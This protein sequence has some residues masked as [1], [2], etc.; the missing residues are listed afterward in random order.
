MKV[1][2]HIISSGIISYIVYLLSANS[3]SNAVASF[4]A[5]ILIDADH[6]LDYFL[7]YG[8]SCNLR[9]IYEVLDKMKINRIYLI[10]HSYELLIIFWASIFLIPLNSLYLAMAIGFTQHI[11]LDQIFNPVMPRAYFLSYRIINKFNKE[12]I[13]DM[14]KMSYKKYGEDN[15]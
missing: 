11:F 6:F 12:S 8:F 14:K 9:N 3:M 1:R 2:N 5:G 10:L 13:T 15:D 4:L 7:N